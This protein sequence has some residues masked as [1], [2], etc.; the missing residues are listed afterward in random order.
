MPPL[1][2]AH[3]QKRTSAW[4]VVFHEAPK[5]VPKQ[6]KPKGRSYLPLGHPP[7]SP[8]CALDDGSPLLSSIASPIAVKAKNAAT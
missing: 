3:T 7:P 4:G 5:Y 2:I 6:T 8:F 1:W